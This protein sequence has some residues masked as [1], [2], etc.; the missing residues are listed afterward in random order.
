[1]L[2]P[3][4][5]MCFN[6]INLS[7]PDDNA[8]EIVNS[9][10]SIYKYA[11]LYQTCQ[12]SYGSGHV[13]FVFALNSVDP[14]NTPIDWQ[15]FYKIQT[16]HITINVF[17][18]IHLIFLEISTLPIVPKQRLGISLIIDV[19]GCPSENL[20]NYT[21]IDKMCRANQ[22]CQPNTIKPIHSLKQRAFHSHTYKRVSFIDSYMA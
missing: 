9:L 14:R 22:L 1:M 6:C 2:T 15:A 7:A 3:G 8:L 13:L 4:G 18:E 19:C 5:I 11:Y 20:D 10:R 12:S 17:T 16:V 21:L